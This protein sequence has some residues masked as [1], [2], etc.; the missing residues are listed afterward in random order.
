MVRNGLGVDTRS[1]YVRAVSATNSKV[2]VVVDGAPFLALGEAL[3]EAL[4]SARAKFGEPEAIAV[5]HDDD[6]S[7]SGREE[8]LEQAKR[9][10][11]GE[12][13]LVAES[14]A[15]PYAEGQDLPAA[16]LAAAGAAIWLLRER[17]G[18]I[19]PPVHLVPPTGEADEGGRKMDD[20]GEGRRMSDFGAGSTMSDHG[21]GRKMEDFGKGRTMADFGAGAQMA[22]FGETSPRRRRSRIVVAAL[23][24]AIVVIAGAVAAVGLSGPS[25]DADNVAATDSTESSEGGGDSD[26]GNTTSTADVI[27][28]G[29]R[30][31]SSVGASDGTAEATTTTTAL[32]TTGGGVTTTTGPGSTTTTVAMRTQ[33]YDVVANVISYAVDAGP[34][35]LTQGQTARGTVTL[36]CPVDG[37]GDCRGSI[38]I[39]D[40]AYRVTDFPAQVVNGHVEYSSTDP[41]PECT[42]A[43]T[44]TITFSADFSPPDQAPSVD[45]TSGHTHKPTR[46]CRG[47]DGNDVFHEDIT[48]GFGTPPR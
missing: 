25:T 38:D 34:P 4:A 27:A 37:S 23:A 24:A 6:L 44:N 8:L 2:L 21:E 46:V 13:R 15:L 31:T 14:T 9:A 11:L 3:R 40:F 47:A 17:R 39:P 12:V 33:T 7:D 22:D 5:V 48:I 26:T 16:A 28:A 36:A 41:V 18:V 30:T 35:R 43:T 32:A 45:G 42:D 20:F 10:G 19:V 29:E 1:G